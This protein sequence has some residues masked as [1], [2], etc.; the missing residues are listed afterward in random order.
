ML[1]LK[2]GSSF[3]LH[4]THNTSPKLH[5][6]KALSCRQ[7]CHNWDLGLGAMCEVVSP[8]FQALNGW[9]YTYWPQVYADLGLGTPCEPALRWGGGPHC[10]AT[11]LRTLKVTNLFK[12][13]FWTLREVLQ[14]LFEVVVNSKVEIWWV[15]I[16]FIT[17]HSLGLGPIGLS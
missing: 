13:F 7:P 1:G 8:N 4:L 9:D 15:C 14:I 3:L 2:V 6:Q 17:S 16:Q 12:K 10:L 5:L 11:N